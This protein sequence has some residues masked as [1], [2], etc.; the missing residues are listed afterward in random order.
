MINQILWFLSL[1]L[2]IIISYQ[3]ISITYK[4]LEKKGK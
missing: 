4:A 2:L 1:P 3:L